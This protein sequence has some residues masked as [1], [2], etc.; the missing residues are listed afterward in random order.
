[1]QRVYSQHHHSTEGGG[2]EEEKYEEM[3]PSRQRKHVANNSHSKCLASTAPT[4]Q[5]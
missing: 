1:M 3:M 4:I 2:S 5:P